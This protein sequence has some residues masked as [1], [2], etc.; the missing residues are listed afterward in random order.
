MWENHAGI[1]AGWVLEVMG[2]E[3][4]EEKESGKGEPLV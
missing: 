1:L 4:R 2:R 3:K